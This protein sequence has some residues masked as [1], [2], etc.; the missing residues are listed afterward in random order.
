MAERG[1]ALGPAPAHRHG[2]DVALPG[3]T[4]GAYG[5]VAEVHGHNDADAALVKVIEA[6]D[7]LVDAVGPLQS[8]DH[9]GAARGVSGADLGCG[10]L[11]GAADRSYVLGQLVELG[12]DR[13]PR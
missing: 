1:E 12:A 11:R 8:E 5:V 2:A 7:V 9:R 13:L 10:R 6:V 4:R 3:Q